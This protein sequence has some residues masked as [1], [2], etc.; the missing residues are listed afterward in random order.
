MSLEVALKMCLR[1]VTG[2]NLGFLANTPTSSFRLMKTTELALGLS[3]ALQQRPL[4][5]YLRGIGNLQWQYALNH[6]WAT[7]RFLPL[8][9]A[10]HLETV[11][12]PIECPD[13]VRYA[14]VLKIFPLV[15]TI[16]K[17]VQQFSRMVNVENPLTVSQRRAVAVTKKGN[18]SVGPRLPTFAALD[19]AGA[20]ADLRPVFQRV[21]CKQR[22]H[23]Q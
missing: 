15:S 9:S 21:S 22:T 10:L 1:S 7:N 2:V 18:G 13:L 6:A 19:A 8:S 17:K 3:L 23:Y 20:L 14:I 5:V 16:F 4:I 12:A 11:F